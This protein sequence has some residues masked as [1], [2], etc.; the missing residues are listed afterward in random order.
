MS[1][2]SAFQTQILDKLAAPLMAAIAD[3]ASRK[4]DGAD[5]I[6]QEDAEN[7]AILLNKSVHMAIALAS[8]MDLTASSESADAGRL[9]LAGVVTPV[10]ASFY[11]QTGKPP[12]DNDVKR[13]I[14]AMEA[15]LTFADSFAPVGENTAR[16]ENIRAGDVLQDED[17][18]SIRYVNIM[19]PLVN[20]IASF[21]FG[22]QDT[23][24]VQEVGDIL[25]ARATE[26]AGQNKDDKIYAL[27]VLQSLVD[28]YVECHRAEKIRLMSM[29]DMERA[30]MSE[31]GG[32]MMPMDGVWKAFDTRAAMIEILAGSRH[33]KSI[34]GGASVTEPQAQPAAPVLQSAPE[35]VAQ[36]PMAPPPAPETAP[37]AAPDTG[38]S[39]MSMFASGDSPVKEAPRDVVAEPVA[40]DDYQYQNDDEDGDGEDEG[41]YNP[42]SF[43][44]KS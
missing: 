33:N 18:I 26:I 40:I 14:K 8:S 2:R 1:A 32:G 42:M 3:V 41:S 30:R 39:P 37:M 22:R 9:A 43:F 23:K 25:V 36:A 31:E 7:L 21:S 19:G 6:L 27:G 16:L 13:M 44:T 15:A 28:I 34:L 10:I 38:A 35:P 12:S 5:I 17:Q 24:L 29:D 20:A 11:R 4:R